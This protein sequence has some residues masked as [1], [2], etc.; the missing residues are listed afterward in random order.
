MI[1][2]ESESTWAVIL[3]SRQ[4]RSRYAVGTESIS[5]PFK[6]IFNLLSAKLSEVLEFYYFIFITTALP[7]DSNPRN[8][9]TSAIL[10]NR[11]LYIQFR[12]T[13]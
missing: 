5:E 11:R 13:S 10:R 9:L 1:E 8:S 6:L 2:G 12:P 4:K 3:N 7:I